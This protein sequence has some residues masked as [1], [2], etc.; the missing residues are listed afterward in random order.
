[1]KIKLLIIGL[2][3][4]A[5]A[6]V[7]LSGQSSMKLPEKEPIAFI[8]HGA[9]FDRSGKEINVTPQ[10]IKEAQEFYINLLLKQTS[11]G[12]RAKFNEKRGAFL[13]SEIFKEQQSKL[14]ADSLLLDSLLKEVKP[15]NA[16]EIAG[17]LNMLKKIIR[18]KKLSEINQPISSRE[19]E[20]IK[21]PDIVESQFKEQGLIDKKFNFFTTKSSSA[22]TPADKSEKVAYLSQCRDS[23][24][25]IP[26]D[27]GDSKWVSKGILD[28]EFISSPLEA[29]VFA[30]DS[31]APEGVCIALPR[32]NGDTIE[33]LGIIYRDK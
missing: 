9:I 14:A 28:N 8:G 33:L 4:T 32:S 13:K 16:G 27:W 26:P 6:V 3:I 20:T 29:E 21:L 19:K 1:M 22:A 5:Y 17:K 2:F 7:Y 31:T 30:Y 25:P 23:G 24:V 15:S 18:T 10:F 11:P 12:I